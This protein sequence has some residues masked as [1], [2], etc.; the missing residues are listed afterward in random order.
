MS[1]LVVSTLRAARSSARRDLRYE[2][3]RESGNASGGVVVS[4]VLTLPK[5]RPVDRSAAGGERLRVYGINPSVAM[6][7]LCERVTTR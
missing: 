6:E 7:T 5:P 1:S 2:G 3:E 4:M